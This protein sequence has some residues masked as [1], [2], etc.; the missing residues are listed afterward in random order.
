MI[1]LDCVGIGPNLHA[2][3]GENY[4]DLYRY[5]NQANTNYVH[6]NLTT[7]LSSNLGRP[8]SDAAIFMQAGIPTV[9]FSSYGG[10]G[11]YHTP[12]DTPSTIWSETLEDVATMLTLAIADLAVPVVK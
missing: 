1:N 5:I 7:S 8:R 4:P 2:G 10:S 11:A 6:R 3:G 12:D 9:S